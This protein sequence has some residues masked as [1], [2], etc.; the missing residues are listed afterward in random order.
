MCALWMAYM[1]LVQKHKSGTPDIVICILV[2]QPA[3]LGMH[4][5]L[6]HGDE[7]IA[8]SEEAGSISAATDKY[9]LWL[10]KAFP[11]SS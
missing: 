1:R 9:K 5:I 11:A 4:V 7:V 3:N 10:R 2:G 6:V 8:D